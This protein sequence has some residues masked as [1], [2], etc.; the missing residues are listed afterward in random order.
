[1]EVLKDR[2]GNLRLAPLFDNGLS[3]CFSAFSAKQLQDIN[4]LQDIVSN[5]YLGSRS[6]E[7]NLIRFVPANL[8]VGRL[9]EVDADALVQGLEQ[10][11]SHAVEGVSGKELLRFIWNMIWERWRVYESLRDSRRLQAQG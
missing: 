7:E 3:L 9:H 11:A 4:P 2:M 6:L 1:M 5:N 8:P 10:P